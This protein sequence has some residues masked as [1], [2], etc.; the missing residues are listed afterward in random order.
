MTCVLSKLGGCSCR[1]M[2]EFYLSQGFR[3]RPLAL[4]YREFVYSGASRLHVGLGYCA[5]V[6]LRMRS[7]SSVDVGNG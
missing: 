5:F 1:W 2:E 4:V 6:I 3:D 7:A